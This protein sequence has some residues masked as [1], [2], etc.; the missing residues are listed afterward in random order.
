M[1]ISA[2]EEKYGEKKPEMKTETQTEK[3]RYF[4]Y[5]LV[6]LEI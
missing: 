6:H 4:K 3:Y 5:F 1:N 2:T